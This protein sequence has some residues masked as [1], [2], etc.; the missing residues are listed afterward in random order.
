MQRVKRAAGSSRRRQRERQPENV[1]AFIRVGP[2]E[3]SVLV[4]EADPEVQVQMARTLR[5]EGHR[6]VGTSSGDG[7]L[8]L[9]SQWD[10]D[11]ILISEDLPGR[12]GIEVTRL[13]A[14][15]QPQAPVIVMSINAEPSM[16]AAARSAGAVDCLLKPLQIEQLARWLAPP[17]L[18]GIQSHAPR[19][20]HEAVAE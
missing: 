7:A 6:V 9:V 15:A 12:A 19:D 2:R 13:I 5:R 16:R 14:A 8:A 4:V 11:L 1:P 17:E 3:R 20:E 10:V 18:D